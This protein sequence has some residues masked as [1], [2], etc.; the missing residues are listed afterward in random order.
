MRKTL[1]VLLAG[2]ALSLGSLATANASTLPY[3]GHA[4]S[5]LN[6]TPIENAAC[7]GW[8]PWCGPGYTPI[9]RGGRCWCRPC[10]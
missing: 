1:L 5:N 3:I 7:R 6:M 2:A 8:G 10:W 4:K 9:C